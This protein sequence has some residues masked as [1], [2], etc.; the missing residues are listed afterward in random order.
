VAIPVRSSIV[1]PSFGRN[2]TPLLFAFL[3]AASDFN[4]TFPGERPTKGASPESDR[5]GPRS[6]LLLDSPITQEYK[7]ASA[8]P[9]KGNKFRRLWCLPTR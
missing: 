6:I 4:L 5:G 7:P 9:T 1:G 3:P 2:V 8:V